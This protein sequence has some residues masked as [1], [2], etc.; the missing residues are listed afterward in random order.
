MRVRLAIAW[1]VLALGAGAAP[2]SDV[3]AVGLQ[4]A[5]VEENG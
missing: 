4:M 2:L 1:A 5:S 3:A